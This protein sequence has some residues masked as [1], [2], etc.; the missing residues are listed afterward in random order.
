MPDL[1]LTVL[2]EE[3]S[4]HLAATY[5]YVIEQPGADRMFLVGWDKAITVTGMPAYFAADATQTFTPSPLKHGP[6]TTSDRFE[7]RSTSLV[8]TTEN[9][10]LRRF[11]TTSAP[12]RLKAWIIRLVGDRLRDTRELKWEQNCYVVEA[13]IISTFTFRGHEIAAQITPE[14]FHTD[15]AIPRFYFERQ[16]NHQLYGDGCGLAKADWKFETE[17]VSINPAQR[18]IVVAGQAPG[19]IENRF[20]AGHLLHAATGLFFTIGWSAYDGTDTKFKLLTWH[21]EMAISDTLTAYFGCRHT[22]EDC[23]LFAN[24]ANFGGFPKVPAS[25]PTLQ[26]VV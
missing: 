3:Q 7:H 11:F 14:A 18:E 21:P 9:E 23:T 2:A 13:G 20:Q 1:P 19:V 10:S 22:V 12:V 16:C 8:L 4:P 5:A 25:N 26:G 6:I 17:I 24:L 15:R